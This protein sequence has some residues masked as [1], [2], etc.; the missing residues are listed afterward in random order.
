MGQASDP[1]GV[2]LVD[3]P[4]GMTSHDVVA[5]VRRAS[6]ESRIGHA[7]T[8]DPFATGLLVLLLGRATR[9]LP[10]LNGEPKVYEACI[11]FG[12]ETDTD[13]Y[14]GATTG[15]GPV[16]ALAD[17]RVAL[18][19]FVGAVSQVP[20]A[21]SAKQIGGRRAYRAARSGA[22]LALDPVQV[23]V[24]QWDVVGWDG[25]MLAARITCGGGTYIRALARDLGRAAGSAAHLITLRRVASGPYRVAHAIDLDAVKGGTISLVSPIDGLADCVTD[26]LDDAGIARVARGLR[27]PAR[28]AGQRGA[29]VD[30]AAELVAVAERQGDEWQPRVVL[31]DE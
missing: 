19:G 25:D 11:K 1:G 20:P 17:I 31:R 10:Y 14:T 2:L 13:D 28:V 18:Q 22:P 9:L 12:V 24:H 29:L 27:V 15:T 23:T 5:I 7:G 6:G 26:H 8:L 3:K 16:P 4:A 21:Y 30:D